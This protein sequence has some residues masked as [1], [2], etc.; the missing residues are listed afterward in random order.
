M[1]SD[2][3]VRRRRNRR[4]VLWGVG[5][6]VV[7]AAVVALR[8]RPLEV[9]A[10][11]VARQSFDVTVDE[12]GNV[13]SAAAV[14]GHPLLRAASVKAAREAKFAPVLLSGQPVKFTGVLVYNFVALSEEN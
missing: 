1:S 10:V 13:I 9:D 2:Q 8:P 3:K 12:D 5:A 7:A 11:N 4:I 6:V 14:S